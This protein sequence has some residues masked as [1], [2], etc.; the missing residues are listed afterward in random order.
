MASEIQNRARFD[1]VRYALCWEDPA[2]LI[3]GLRPHAGGH[4]LSIGSAGDNALALL[5]AGAGH[6][7]IAE[8]N[9]TQIACIELRVAAWLELGYQE[10]L[11]LLGL[12]ASARRKDLYQ[13]VRGRLNEKARSFWDGHPCWNAEGPAH[14]GKFENYFRL[15]RERVLPLAHSR[16]RVLELLEP[17]APDERAAFYE[18][19]WNNWR[20]RAI[21]HL[22]FSRFTMG[23]LGRDPE[24]FRYVKGSVAA[25]ILERTRHAL[26]ELDPSSNPWLRMIL[27]GSFGP[28]LPPAFLPESFHPIREA[29]LANRL[30]IHA[31]PIE[32]VIG[33]PPVDGFNLSDIFEYMSEDS[34]RELL[35]RLAAMAKP[36]A[37]LAYWNMLAPRSRPDALAEILTPLEEEAQEL[38]LHDRA[39]FYSR[40][41]LEEVRA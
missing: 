26:V 37:R 29:L 20:W 15:F 9:P 1:Q 8:L 27:T 18:Q 36:G 31:C 34:T 22:F 30:T 28:H 17:R 25:R 11:E 40:F 19:K 41:V 39:F 21:F 7:S 32:D 23:L 5:A 14:A 10:L 3:A 38:F 35:D 4:Y 2:L 33:L 24:F 6:V 16:R 12:Q 13:A